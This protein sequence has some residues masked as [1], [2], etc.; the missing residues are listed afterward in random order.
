MKKLF[1]T[2]LI[3]L[4]A[5]SSSVFFACGEPNYHEVV[6][7]KVDGVTYVSEF[8]PYMVK[9]GKSISF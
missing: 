4:L 1:L 2:I 5:I 6:Y 9:E 7:T 8:F 3:T